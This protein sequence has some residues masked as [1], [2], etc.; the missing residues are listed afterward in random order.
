MQSKAEPMDEG[1]AEPSKLKPL[2]KKIVDKLVNLLEF[3]MG[4]ANLSKD[5]FL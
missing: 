5:H 2:E 4:D 3:Y 1:S